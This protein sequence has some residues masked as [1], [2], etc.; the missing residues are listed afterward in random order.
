VRLRGQSV[1]RLRWPAAQ[2]E[3][4]L[5]A[6]AA[7]EP[8]AAAEDASTGL[9]Q[10]G[11]REHAAAMRSRDSPPPTSDLVNDVSWSPDHPA[12]L[13]GSGDPLSQCHKTGQRLG[14]DLATAPANLWEGQRGR[15]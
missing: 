4:A 8:A 6:Q 9:G 14:H 3:G 2:L 12:V 13:G 5:H 10:P 15:L 7:L 1:G 11:V